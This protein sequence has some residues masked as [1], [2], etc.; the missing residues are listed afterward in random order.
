MGDSAGGVC[1]FK[2]S[3]LSSDP[4]MQELSILTLAVGD[5]LLC[6]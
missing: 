2:G 4:P 3:P 6:G 1:H 5:M